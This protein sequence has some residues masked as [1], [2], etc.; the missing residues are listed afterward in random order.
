MGQS[1]MLPVSV[2]PAAGLLI[3]LGRVFPEGHLLHELFVQGG[4]SIF[5][6]L[7][8][9]FAVGVAIGLSGGSGSAGLAATVGYFLLQA[10][11]EVASRHLAEDPGQIVMIDTGVVGGILTGLLAAWAF[12]RYSQKKLPDFL[13]FFSG[14]RLVPLVTAGLVVVVSLGLVLLWPPL[15]IGIRDF[16]HWVSQTA[17]GPAF[18]AA[19]KRLL[20]PVGLHHVYY[21]SFLYEFGEMLGPN[22][23]V[24]RGES[25]RYFAGDPTAGRFMASEFPIMLFG[26]PAAALAM[27]LRAP[28]LQRKR[29]AGIML[30]ASLTSILTG[31]T[32]PIEFSFIFVSP[33]LFGIHV[34]LA[35][36]SGILTNTFGL[37]LGYTFS[38]SLIDYAVGFFNQKNSLYLWVLIGP[39]MFGLYFLSFYFV[40]GWRQILTPGRD[41]DQDGPKGDGQLS[42]KASVNLNELRSP[43]NSRFNLDVAAISQALGGHQN[44]ISLEA[45][46]TRLRLRVENPTILDEK[47]LKS[48]GAHGV[49][50][51]GDNVQV[52]FGTQSDE[53]KERLKSFWEIDY[54]FTSPLAGRILPIEEVPDETFRSKMLGDGFAILPTNGQVV[55]PFEGTVSSLLSTHHAIGLT[56]SEGFEVLIHVG[57]DTVKLKGQ[58]FRA[59][60]KEGDV[61][62]Q[63]QVL[64]QF[65]VNFIESHSTSLMTPIVFTEA[66]AWDWKLRPSLQTAQLNQKILSYTKRS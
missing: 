7:P 11:L 26:L 16:G 12:S 20:I 35:F 49:M 19:G 40:I 36:I 29:V 59:L 24:I 46:I 30:S 10:L 27:V 3:A 63:G 32:E 57:I 58:G 2:L 47:A 41:V 43:S 64:L 14:K 28:R 53:L 23:E 15:Q 39:L 31:I 13:G 44:V 34:V 5:K 54:N 1:L 66:S 61:V 50:K 56:S 42:D 65:D 21:P 37:Q 33:L 22:G 62:T 48:L 60:V 8:L 25:A 51:A 6:Q 55:S 18:Y 4:L 38:A 52:V 45:C 17:L 9:L